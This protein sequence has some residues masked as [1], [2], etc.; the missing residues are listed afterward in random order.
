MY[1]SLEISTLQ[2][3][4]QKI[5]LLHQQY[6]NKRKNQIGM[7]TKI[8]RKKVKKILLRLVSCPLIVLLRVRKHMHKTHACLIHL[9]GS[10]K[11]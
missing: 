6:K 9:N 4:I 8:K 10:I 11:L 7:Y 2:I 5:F 3:E 1:R